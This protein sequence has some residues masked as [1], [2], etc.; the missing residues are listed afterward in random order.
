MLVD[1]LHPRVALVALVGAEREQHEPLLELTN[2]QKST[3][4]RKARPTRSTRSTRSHTPRIDPSGS[5]RSFHSCIT[6]LQN[7]LIIILYI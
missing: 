3:T 5:S 1:E 2:N 4:A 7:D 6:G